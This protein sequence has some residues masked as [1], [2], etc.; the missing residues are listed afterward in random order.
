LLL[1]EINS[2]RLEELFIESDSE[3]EIA[4]RGR[5]RVMSIYEARSH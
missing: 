4:I 5:K 2:A 1:D 3:Q